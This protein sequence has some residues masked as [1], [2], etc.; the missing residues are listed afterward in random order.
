MRG[1]SLRIQCIRWGRRRCN[2]EENRHNLCQC[3]SCRIFGSH[4]QTLDLSRQSNQ[5]LFRSDGSFSAWDRPAEERRPLPHL[6]P[7]CW[8][9]PIWGG[10]TRRWFCRSRSAQSRKC[11]QCRRSVCGKP[12]LWT[13]VRRL[14]TAAKVSSV[15]WGCQRWTA[16][17][18][19]SAA[20]SICCL[21]TKWVYVAF[22]SPPQFF[23]QSLFWGPFYASQSLTDTAYF[24]S[25]PS[26][27]FYGSQSS[28][29]TA[30]WASITSAS[31]TI[32]LL[33]TVTAASPNRTLHCDGFFLLR[34][35]TTPPLLPP[36][37]CCSFPCKSNQQFSRTLRWGL[38]N[39]IFCPFFACFRKVPQQKRSQ[40]CT[41]L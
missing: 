41:S 17:A 20:I 40:F 34:W 11:P 28:R 37:I 7:I 21:R 25:Q 15:G 38:P 27:L 18:A 23:S 29:S 9:S 3:C 1:K 16:S 19:P 24:Q 14:W 5:S 32:F 22:L 35:E 6:S 26:E 12:R 39:N 13:D 31:A 2:C 33:C 30:I 8:L 10:W 36:N 4:I